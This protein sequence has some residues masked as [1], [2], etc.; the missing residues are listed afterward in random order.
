M[1]LQKSVRKEPCNCNVPR[2]MHMV[3]EHELAREGSIEE[4]AA[5]HDASKKKNQIGH[6]RQ[7]Q[8]VHLELPV[9]P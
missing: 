6:H 3:C 4:T 8:R 1:V 5:C 7:P 2:P 9:A